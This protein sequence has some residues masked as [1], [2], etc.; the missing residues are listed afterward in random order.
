VQEEISPKLEKLKEE[1]K[2]YNKWTSNKQEIERL[3]RL[4]VAYEFI[5][6]QKL[7]QNSAVDVEQQEANKTSL[8]NQ[9]KELES[10]IDAT[11]TKIDELTAKRTKEQEGELATLEKTV[12]HLSKELV[13]ATSELSHNKEALDTEVKQQQ[14]LR[15]ANDKVSHPTSFPH[16]ELVPFFSFLSF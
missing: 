8:T 5:N 2:N 3:M 13:K 14:S 7:L 10:E 9:L 6:A 1:Q 16:L 4:C 15:S 12:D 11:S